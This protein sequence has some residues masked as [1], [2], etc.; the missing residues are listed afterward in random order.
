V[1]A[2]RAECAQHIHDDAHDPIRLDD[3][4]RT[5]SQARWSR[6]APHKGTSSLRCRRARTSGADTGARGQSPP[7]IVS[8]PT[9]LALLQQ[10]GIVRLVCRSSRR[11]LSQAACLEQII[12]LNRHLLRQ[13]AE[14][15][16]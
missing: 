16:E 5:V 2:R 3:S 14:A 10:D 8:S 7:S 1:S 11:A 12:D 13:S 6:V 4:F 9:T 15:A